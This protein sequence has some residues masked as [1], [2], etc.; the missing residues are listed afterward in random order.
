MSAMNGNE[1]TSTARLRKKAAQCRQL[2][3]Q[4]LS[5]GIAVELGRLADDY[6]ANAA[7]LEAFDSERGRVK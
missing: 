7:Q 3:R 4:A 6:D 2:A 1:T 5:D